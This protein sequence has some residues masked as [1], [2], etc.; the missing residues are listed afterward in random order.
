MGGVRSEWKLET[1]LQVLL[2][3]MVTTENAVSMQADE[4]LE[5]SLGVQVILALDHKGC[6]VEYWK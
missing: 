6:L 3:N 5:K 4:V 2:I 1:L